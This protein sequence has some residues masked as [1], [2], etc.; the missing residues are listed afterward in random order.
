MG[1]CGSSGLTQL[2]LD[3]LDRLTAERDELRGKLASCQEAQRVVEEQG[4]LLRYKMELLVQMLGVEEKKTGTLQ[5]RLEASKFLALSQGLSERKM[6]QVLESTDL[7]ASM[8]SSGSV[9]RGK[10][11]DLG[12]AI[13]RMQAEMDTY[14]L[15]VV[16]SFADTD[17]RIAAAM[18]QEVG[19]SF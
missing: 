18:T 11:V 8:R 14:T 10:P 3:E 15:E 16:Q 17:D 13:I 5:R 4:N 12:G 2:Q 7:S 19:I 1:A 9:L 6:N